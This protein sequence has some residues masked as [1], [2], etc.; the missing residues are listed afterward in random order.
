MAPPEITERA[1]LSS[2]TCIHR[3]RMNPSKNN[4]QLQQY[5]AG[6]VCFIAEQGA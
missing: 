4:A 5:V 3:L 2:S 1:K 6:I